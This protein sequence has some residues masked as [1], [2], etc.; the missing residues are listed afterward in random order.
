MTENTLS[1]EEIKPTIKHLDETLTMTVPEWGKS[2]GLSRGA[3][4][5]AA[6]RGDIPGLI[7]IGKRL[8]V[9]KIAAQKAL[10]HGWTPPQESKS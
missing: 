2:W 7:R 1:P 5:A 4:Y 9:S 6:A 10:E 8:M 3:S